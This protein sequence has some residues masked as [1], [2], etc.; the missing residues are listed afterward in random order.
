MAR[1]SL[2]TCFGERP[3]SSGRFSCLE[4]RVIS[5]KYGLV[6]SP[7]QR[8]LSSLAFSTSA[9][10]T[11]SAPMCSLLNRTR[12]LA[13]MISPS[14]LTRLAKTRYQMLSAVPP[15]TLWSSSG[16]FLF[17]RVVFTLM[18]LETVLDLV[19]IVPLGAGFCQGQRNPLPWQSPLFCFLPC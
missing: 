11:F 7:S 9:F 12:C 4:R 18:A 19:L 6:C 17:P 8:P 14:L 5:S 10:T 13:S 16:R 15:P 2:R 1:A 3:L